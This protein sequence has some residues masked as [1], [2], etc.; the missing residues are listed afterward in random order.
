MSNQFSLS[1][2]DSLEF[3]RIVSARLGELGWSLT[4]L[5]KRAG[6]S[7]SEVS[8]HLSGRKR[9]RIDIARAIAEAL[10]I[11]PPMPEDSKTPLWD[12]TEHSVGTYMDLVSPFLEGHGAELI[13]SDWPVTRLL[14]REQGM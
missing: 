6:L 3:R 9:L 1:P 14:S 11:K 5:A 13:Y 10:G 4:E 8:R 7:P 2:E 12:P